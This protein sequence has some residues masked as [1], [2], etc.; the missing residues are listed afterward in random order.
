MEIHWQIF[1]H[2][3]LAP[4]FEDTDDIPL[5]QI[6]R[7]Y[8]IES[9]IKAYNMLVTVKRGFEKALKYRLKEL[10]GSVSRAQSEFQEI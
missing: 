5:K 6:C 2:K 9:E 8:H 7:M 1:Y 3:I 10:T 4:I